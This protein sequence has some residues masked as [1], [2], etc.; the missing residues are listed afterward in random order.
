MNRWRVTY[1]YLATGMEGNPDIRDYGVVSAA[2]AKEACHIIAERETS[3]L[4]D[5]SWMMSCLSAK[6]ENS[7]AHY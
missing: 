3:N 2:T 4:E 6:E 7:F 1:Y 5:Q